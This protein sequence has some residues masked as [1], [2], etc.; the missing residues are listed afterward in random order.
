MKTPTLEPLFD[1]LMSRLTSVERAIA[2]HH[3]FHVPVP[4]NYYSQVK[5]LES[6]LLKLGPEDKL[7]HPAPGAEGEVRGGASEVG[8][9]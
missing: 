9:C 5:F 6:I 1:W 3:A 8:P 2:S 7:E 4:K